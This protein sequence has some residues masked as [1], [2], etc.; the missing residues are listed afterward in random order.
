MGA[1]PQRRRFLQDLTVGLVAPA[2]AAPAW[3]AIA[4]A[5]GSTTSTIRIRAVTTS[6][7]SDNERM[8]SYRH[9]Q[10]L[11][12]SS[13]GALHLL[14]NRGSLAPDPGLSLYSS[15][16]GGETWQ[17]MQNFAGTDDKSTG[18]VLLVGDDLWLVFH[19]GD[20]RVMFA[21]LHYDSIGRTCSL[22]ELQEAF[23]S[24]QWNAQNPALAI[25]EM[26]TIW[27]GFLAKTPTR[28]HSLGNIR[29]VNRVGGG[30]TWTDPGLIFGPTDQ[31]A[32]E[33]S[34]RPVHI[35]G[36]MG[37]VW[38]VHETTYWSTRSNALPDNSAWTTRTLFVG[39]PAKRIGDPYASHFNVAIDD[40]GGLHLI[41]IDSNDILYF[42]YAPATDTWSAPQQIDDSR[43][44][45]YAQ[46]GLVDGELGVG[47]S[48]QRGK[49][50]LS[51]SGDLGATW[52]PYADL[53]LPPTYPG[54]N[55][56][57]GRVELPS[58]STGTLP[59]LQQYSDDES[60]KLMLF[61][62]PLA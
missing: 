9:Q 2:L 24:P 38:T 46:I 51:A 35:P 43:K 17:L 28:R 25:D 48:V 11:V 1:L 7:R 54:V 29:V 32:V 3:A 26:G 37:M 31:Q 39:T 59:I 18:D 27:V 34:A 16:D 30:T 55:Y 47:F 40:L 44:V 21:R 22:L 33:R 45:A 20:Q 23:T 62:I 57:T 52:A 42:K 49:G 13:D 50:Q 8:I 5:R 14:F 53:V 58:R 36:G 61:K 19:T 6:L 41:T 10:H 56:N 12:Q 15:F 4:P 60:Q